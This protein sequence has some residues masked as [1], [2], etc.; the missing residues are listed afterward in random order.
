[1]S[2]ISFCMN[3][4]PFVHPFTFFSSV[5]LRYK[6]HIALNLVQGVQLNDLIPV[7]IAK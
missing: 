7:Y 5:L 6:R 3:V 4:P 1:M 2:C